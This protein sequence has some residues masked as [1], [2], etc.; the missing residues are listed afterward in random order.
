M[1]AT[2]RMN[3]TPMDRAPRDRF[4]F[5]RSYWNRNCSAVKKYRRPGGSGRRIGFLVIGFRSDR[6]VK[7][8][9]RRLVPPSFQT[10][11]LALANR[12]GQPHAP[13]RSSWT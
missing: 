5:M 2:P 12:S 6:V 10:T 3:R 13:K 9:L 4:L 1:I 7:R 8:L 11:K